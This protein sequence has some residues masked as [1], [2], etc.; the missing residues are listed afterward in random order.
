MTRTLWRLLASVTVVFTAG[1]A[2]EGVP[3]NPMDPTPPQA[4]VP[5]AWR[6]SALPATAGPAPAPRTH[7]VAVWDPD[8]RRLVVFGGRG[9][10]GLLNDTWA[11]DPATRTWTALATRG[12][13]PDPRL[14]A[15]AVYD[16]VARQM[17][18]WAGQQGSRF[19]DDTWTLDLRTLEW[20]NV[21]PP[22]RPQARYGASAVFDGGERRLVQFAGFTSVFRRFEDTQGFDL[23]TGGWEDMTPS[24]ARPPARCLHTAGLD[25]TSRQMIVYGGQQNGPLDDVWSYDLGTR[26]WTELTPATRPAGRM[27][28]VS[29]V[30]EGR[31]F[32]FGGATRSGAVNETWTFDP[33]MRTW[34]PLDAG[35]PPSPRQAPQAAYDA[36]GQRFVVYGGEGDGL[37]ND[38]W[39]LAY[40]PVG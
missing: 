13:L 17:V 1:C 24:E 30:A 10:Q 33:A 31:L 34:S 2:G 25:T 15:S 14:G 23:D 11:F 29:F 28:A 4:P 37:L 9:D 36:E 38:V 3:D 7:G 26:R 20:R 6:W 16:A 35:A 18:M 12:A 8:A 40:V 19:F 27:L 39:T 5:R 32:V 22:V 21:S